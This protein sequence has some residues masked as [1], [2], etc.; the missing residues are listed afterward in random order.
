MI[1]KISFSILLILSG[2][3]FAQ[4]PAEIKLTAEKLH[5]RVREW[6]YPVNGITPHANTNYCE[7][8][9]I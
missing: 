9:I 2:K 1:K 4:Q 5:S 7:Y 8:K 3:V 6:P